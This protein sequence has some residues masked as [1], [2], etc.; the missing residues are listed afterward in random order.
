MK[1]VPGLYESAV[2]EALA[3]ALQGLE[4]AAPIREA[5]TREAGPHVLARLLYDA[6]LKAL[7]A[8]GGE[9]Q[10]EAQVLLANRLLEVL[11]EASKDSGITRDDW[12]KQPAELLLAIRREADRRLGSAD[13]VRPSLPL[14]H[15]DLLVNGPRDLRVGNEVRRELASA[16]R[17]DLLLS[18]VKWSGIRLL[19][20]ELREFVERRPGG[21]RVLTTTYMGATEAIALEFLLDELK[22]D[23]RISYDTRRTRLHAK[24]WLF[25]RDTGFS[26]GLVGSSN[27]S[28]A[29][30]LDGIEWNVRLSSVDNGPIL[31]KFVTTFDQYWADGEFEPYDRARFLEAT[32]HRDADRDALARAVQLRPYRHQQA[33]LDALE[34]E[35]SRGH[36]RNLIVAATGSG[37]TVIAALDYARLCRDGV[38]PPLLFVAHRQE[39]LKQSLATFR[40]AMRDGH[41]GELL[42]A[43]ERP[44]LGRHLFASVQS[45][46]AARLETLE[47]DAYEVL[48]VDEFHHAEADTYRRLLEHFAPKTLLGLTAT[49][50]R[51][52]G[53]DVLAWFDRRIS[54]E[55]RLWDAIDQELV[56]PFHYFGIHDGTD[57]STVDFK[58]GR[59]DVTALERLYTAD[60]V[61]ALAVLRELER[62]TS[63]VDALRALGFCVSVKHAEFMA[64][65]FTNKGVPAL[66]VSGQ[67]PALERARALEQL[68]S[69]AVKVLFSRDLFNEGLDLPAVNTV[70]FLRPTESATVFLQQLGRGLRRE[71]GKACLTVLD[72]VGSARREFRFDERFRALTGVSTRREV[73]RAV[74]E[75]FPHLPAGC[76]IRLDRQT[77]RAVLENVRAHLGS[78]TNE[79]LA[80]LR[81]LG[82]VRLPEFLGACGLTPEELYRDNESTRVLANMKRQLKLRPGDQLELEPARALARVLHVDDHERL[83]RWL[84][85]LRAPSPPTDV[86]DPHA[87]ML[88]SVLGYVRSEV[89]ELPRHFAE[90]WRERDLVEELEDLFELLADR[91]RRPSHALPGLPF[92]VHA[93]YSRD[94]ISAGLKEIRK[95]KLMRTQGGV[96]KVDDARADVFYVTLDKDPKRFTPT[97]L[98]N[99]YPVSPTRFH[100]ESQS[101]TRADSPTGQRYQRA[102]KDPSWRTLLFVR[103]SKESAIGT[104]APYLFLGPVRYVSHEREKPM[105]IIWELER[106][107][108]PAFFAEAKV[109]AG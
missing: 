44:V 20:D 74:E 79:L 57:L 58:A 33:A 75:G 30:M 103:R 81:G 32:V 68:R 99:D 35:R 49:P 29:A 19:R 56:V 13:V 86:T 26:T 45:L 62:H 102:G 84:E 61:R 106:A 88:F 65:F 10:L 82:D 39:L 40:A 4:G 34:A 16:D 11:G 36:H 46:H 22:A 38:R 94:E 70:L 8:I 41:F 55:L 95:G 37:K 101:A 67:T 51:A 21:L 91:I 63:R 107:M 92:R 77:Q 85:W 80:D 50:E 59:Y 53:R 108:P 90:V 9:A 71:E 5:L 104:T 42:V 60:D 98:Y 43:D 52:D 100:W 69:G 6:A 14:R 48:V 109:A 25:H 76:E 2:T 24:A 78:R 27:L 64:Q 73:E 18:F 83:G 72:F 97:T 105:Q 54:F 17:V 28:S 47:K 96:F 7:R 15:S 66:A 3:A 87:L 12:V 1:L 31:S 93:T 23:I 89:A